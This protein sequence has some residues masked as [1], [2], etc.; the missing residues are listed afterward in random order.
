MRAGRFGMATRA[1]RQRAEELEHPEVS[2]Q[3]AQHRELAAAGARGDVDE[4][5]RVPERKDRRQD[6]E[7][8]LGGGPLEPGNDLGP[9]D[10]DDLDRRKVFKTVENGF[11]AFLWNRRAGWI[12]RI[13]LHRYTSST[14]TLLCP[15]GG[16][17]NRS[18]SAQHLYLGENICE[19]H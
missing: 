12:E 18:I 15:L 2:Q 16:T 9:G 10:A 13:T 17:V 19:N 3:N 14:D 11:D 5:G 7:E 8:V 6:G 1:A 4:G